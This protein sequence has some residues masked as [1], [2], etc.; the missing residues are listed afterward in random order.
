MSS[1]DDLLAALK[2]HGTQEKAAAALGIA[3]STLTRRLKRSGAI[4]TP[5][6]KAAG[7]SLVDFRNLYDKSTIIPKR[8]DA[9]LKQLGGSGWEF[10][11]QFAKM[12]GVSLVDLGHFRDQ[13]AEHVVT[14]NRDSKRA[15][16]GTKA[17]AQ[18]MREM[19][20]VMP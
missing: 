4:P 10:E 9:A 12:A 3:R 19:L 6:P 13:Y 16:A 2:K 15:W 7:K 5:E 14:L 17:A 18:K 11:V 1:N 20:G 8:I